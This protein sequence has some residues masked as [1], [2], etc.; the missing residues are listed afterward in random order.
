MTY[1]APGRLDTRNSTTLDTAQAAQSA[2]SPC[3]DTGPGK[4]QQRPP[5]DT[6]STAGTQVHLPGGMLTAR[7]TY[8]AMLSVGKLAAGP[9]AGRYYEDAVALGREDCD[10]G[11]GERPGRW[12]GSGSDVL[13][14]EGE[15][16]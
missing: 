12:L 16:H 10:V 7:A 11:E 5:H 1:W 14:L 15:A 3:D 9:S 8:V 13:G 4:Q 6:T 2:P